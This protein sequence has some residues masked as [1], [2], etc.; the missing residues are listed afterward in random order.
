MHIIG[1]LRPTEGSVD[2]FGIDPADN[3]N[4]IQRKVGVVVQ[5][6]ED[7]MIGPTVFD[8]IAFSLI[9]YGF[10]EDEISKR[11]NGIM[12]EMKIEKLQDKLIHYL[13]GGE[14]KKVALAGALVLYPK[15]LI[16]DEVL[17]GI[18]I[19]SVDLILGILDRFN[20]EYKT[21]IIMATNEIEIVEK[22]SQKVYLLDKGEIVFSGPFKDLVKKYNNYTVCKH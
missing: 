5:R 8:D 14:K 13:S 1:L 15:L 6:A 10:S 18:D 17:S 7:Q 11:V 20:K 4:D 9:N 16:L 2:V 22:F 12:E 19:E 3:F 21:A